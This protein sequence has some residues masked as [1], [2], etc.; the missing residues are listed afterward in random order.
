MGERDYFEIVR[1]TAAPRQRI[2]PYQFGAQ[3]RV[4]GKESRSARWRPGDTPWA[5][6][7]LDALSDQSPYQR[8]VCPKGTQ[9]GFTEIGLI[10]V[11]QGIVEG[12]SALIVE[13]TETTA[14]KVV[15]SKFRPMLL[16][17]TL[18]RDVFAGRSA[19]ASLLFSAPSVDITFAGSNSA[20]NFASVTVP[21]AFGDEI[22]RWDAELLDEGDPLELI[23]NRVADYG[24]LG[25]TFLPCSPTVEGASLI[26]RAFLESNQCY[27]ETPCPHCGVKQAWLWENMHW[28]AGQPATIQLF[29]TAQDCGAGATEHAWKSAWHDGEWRATCDTPQRGDTIGFHL[30]A[31]YGRF[32][33]RS[34]AQI[35]Q[36]YEAIV[37][38]GSPAERMQPFTNTIL[39][40]PW[41]V[42]D[43]A[44]KV[45][46]LRARLEDYARGV[47][48]AGGLALSAG[49][50]YQKNRLEAFV[51]AWG[52]R[53]ERWLVAKIEI[54]RLNA[55]G[56][57]RSAKDLAEDLKAQVL[58]V[59][60]PHEL[61]GSLRLEQTVHDSNDRPADVYDVLDYLPR[62]TNLAKHSV[63]GW[64]QQL[65]YAPPK[66]VDVRRDGKVVKQGRL[67]MRIHASVAKRDWYEDLMKPLEAEGPSE[68]YVHLPKWID[69]EE[70]LLEQ[71]VAEE[72]RRSSRG[73]PVWHKVHTRNEGL[74]CAVMGD[75][76]RW[77]MKTHRWSEPEWLR[78]EAL[79][80][81]TTQQTP[82]SGPSSQTTSSGR[83]IRGRFR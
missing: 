66:V 63:D 35:A 6:G 18:L 71:F 38:A 24:F 55:E 27:F 57:D 17:T 22:D 26:W 44:P 14:K 25:K 49:V 10:W 76:A 4:Y 64:T 54:P 60:W 81:V 33:G 82:P 1:R 32:G 58:D 83:R 41:K 47:I 36:Q 34:W 5:K 50:D 67:R 8:I 3:H 51:W 72:I 43:D 30:S 69:E 29:C 59:D 28:T 53:R 31:L 52:R 39:G 23:S 19:F 7:I 79:V 65:P 16:S 11:G 70:G 75:A 2:S 68:R 21:R 62:A 78:R 13:P 15:N 48:P 46:T 74:D 40:L 37:A 73:K 12:Q 80:K 77:H 9:L 20:A 61:G 45:D 42:S 56:K